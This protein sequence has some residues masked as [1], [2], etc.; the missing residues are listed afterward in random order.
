MLYRYTCRPNSICYI[1]LGLNSWSWPWNFAVHDLTFYRIC[2]HTG[3]QL[4]YLEA[5]YS[6]WYE[7]VEDNVE[8]RESASRSGEV[9]QV[10]SGSIM[11]GMATQATN[12]V[13]ITMW[14]RLRIMYNSKN[15]KNHH[16]KLLHYNGKLSITIMWN[17]C[18]AIMVRIIMQKLL[19]NTTS[20]H[21]CPTFWLL[22]GWTD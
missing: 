9:E 7:S 1:Y 18:I 14:K 16:V 17:Q 10:M 3:H 20:H 22:G 21:P 13:R 4:S 15:G 2:I 6:W 5:I 19:H 11:R 8:V 12:M